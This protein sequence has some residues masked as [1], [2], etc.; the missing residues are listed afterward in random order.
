MLR[1]IGTSFALKEGGNK[2]WKNK[3]APEIVQDIEVV[4]YLKNLM[5]LL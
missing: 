2:I 5:V 3:T 1:G 4:D